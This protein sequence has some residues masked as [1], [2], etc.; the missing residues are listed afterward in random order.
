MSNVL[1]G[2]MREVGKRGA[3]GGLVNLIV[4]DFVVQA[5]PADLEELGSLRPIFSSLLERL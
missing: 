3:F 2:R 1:D 4:T 5:R